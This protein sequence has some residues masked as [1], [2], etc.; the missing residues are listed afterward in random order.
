MMLGE[1]SLLV[2]FP[3]INLEL[4][5]PQSNPKSSETICDFQLAIRRAGATD[6]GIHWV[7][8]AV[9]AVLALAR[10]A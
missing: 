1:L 9:V 5:R 7:G 6:L 8:I 4:I 3:V 2:R 10:I